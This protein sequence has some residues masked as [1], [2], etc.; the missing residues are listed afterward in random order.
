MNIYLIG[1]MGSGKSTIG[2]MVGDKMQLSFI[3]LDQEI[4]NLTGKTINEIF[5]KDGE[6]FFRKVESECLRLHSNAVL[7]CGGGI[8]LKTKNRS[9]IKKHGKVILLKASVSELAKRLASSNKRPL[10]NKQ[11]PKKGL[12]EL[13]SDRK[14]KYIN[15]ADITI[16]TDN[17][18]PQDISEEIVE[19]LEG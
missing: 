16:A 14:S 19:K 10:F 5:K 6:E 12:E 17:R 4:E 3:D 13:W 11:N 8:V 9:Y 18:S 2:H 1:M 7:A 15:M